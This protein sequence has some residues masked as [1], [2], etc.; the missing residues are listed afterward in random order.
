ML[1]RARRLKLASASNTELMAQ[2]QLFLLAS[3]SMRALIITNTSL[4][5][6]RTDRTYTKRHTTSSFFTDCR[7]SSNIH[8]EATLL[9]SIF[10]VEPS[11]CRNINFKT[12]CLCCFRFWKIRIKKCPFP[13][14]KTSV[15]SRS[16]YNSILWLFFFYK[17]TFSIPNL[18]Q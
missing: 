9:S 7:F 4:I 5:R 3:L 11:R 10:N 17:M 6:H 16:A 14:S 8:E 18:A 15:P 2:R 1:L 13:S 12:I